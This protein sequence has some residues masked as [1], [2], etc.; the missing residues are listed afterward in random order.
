MKLAIFDFDGT[1]FRKD[2]LPFLGQE[3]LRQGKSKFTYIKTY[4]VCTPCLVFYKL[5]LWPREKMKVKILA[6]F[7]GL[8]K[9]MTRDDIDQFFRQAYPA[10]KTY[11]NSQVLEELRRAQHQGYHCVILSGAYAQMLNIVAEELGFDTVIAVEI[12]YKNGKVDLKKPLSV[13]DGK[14]KSVLLKRV[15]KDEK[16]NWK[17]SRSYGD[18]YS[19]IPIMEIVGEPVAVNPDPGL[20]AHVEKSG[21]RCLW[22]QAP[23]AVQINS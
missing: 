14:T 10:M 12:H 18:S 13:I 15:F 3:W 1:L 4:L 8:F 7:H 23:K 11:F 22:G 16:I 21:W 6:Q 20:E 2:T 19:D 17:L 5:G 9:N